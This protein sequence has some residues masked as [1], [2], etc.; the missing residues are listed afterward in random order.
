MFL[1]DA[2]AD[3]EREAQT[4]LDLYA[5]SADEERAFAS[6]AG[7][8]TELALA[9]VHGGRLDGAREAL[10][11]VLT[12]AP[13]HRIG[14]ILHGL[15]HVHQALRDSRYVGSVPARDL[16]ESIETFSRTPAATLAS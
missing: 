12:L 13:E 11:D 10:S 16:R 15:Q 3:A 6:E 5:S 1:E 4:A 9:R 8:R 14:G 2:D 7:A